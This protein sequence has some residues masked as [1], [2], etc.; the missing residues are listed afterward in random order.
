MH[1]ALNLGILRMNSDYLNKQQMN[2][3]QTLDWLFQQLPMYQRQG[4]TA[5]KV[6]LTNIKL[7]SQHLNSPE[8]NFRSIHVGGT[9]GKGSTSHMLAS[10]L[11]EAGYKV[12]IYTS[13]HLVDFRE[14][15]RIN[16]EMIPKETVVEFVKQ[17]KTFFE[18]HAL[19]FFEMTVG[20]AFQHFAEEQIDIAII[21][22]GL[23]GRLDSTNIIHPEIS[24]IT[25][26]SLEHTEFLG[27]S[28]AEIA[29]EKG[30]IIKS[31]TPCVIGEYNE[32]TYPVF[33]TLAKLNEADLHL[34]SQENN[35]K[36]RA[37][38]L[39][40]D[41]QQKNIQ[42]VLKTIEILNQQEDWI[43]TE[44]ALTLGL[45]K[46]VENTH[47]K[48]RWQICGNSPKIICDT[49]HNASGLQLV[50]QQLQ[51]E[52][53]N[54]LYIVLGVVKEKNLD[55]I[56]GLLPTDAYYYFTKPSIPRGLLAEELAES[57]KHF[58]LIGERCEN[59]ASAIRKAKNKAKENDL[60]FIG[61]SNFTVADFLILDV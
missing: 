43:I 9:N 23:G 56:L 51:K 21:E 29:Y 35:S 46:V 17:N 18:Q 36:K 2:Y 45:Q 8:N 60:I 32:Q 15:I 7:L 38:D 31:K 49:A 19:S 57:A 33:R 25:N 59:V 61:G 3:Q 26:I 40:G 39:L 10:V 5:Y 22:V 50:M 12:G 24:V 47:L 11:Q 41:Y 52:S 53:Y 4:A 20:M 37:T 58:N 54:K 34:A 27:N 1:Q 30:G 14:R 13:P 44:E 48:G 55:L 42:T 28:L 6:D 16:G